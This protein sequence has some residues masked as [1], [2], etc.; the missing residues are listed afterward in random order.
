MYGKTFKYSFKKYNLKTELKGRK[1]KTKNIV[2]TKQWTERWVK[3]KKLSDAETSNLP[4]GIQQKPV[5]AG[6]G[7]WQKGK[8][9]A[10]KI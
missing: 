10:D 4:E 8:R 7:S 6:W 2:L 5:T 1:W 9:Q 3:N